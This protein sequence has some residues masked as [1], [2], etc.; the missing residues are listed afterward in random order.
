MSDHKHDHRKTYLNVWF[1]LMALTVITVVA[2]SINFGKINLFIAMAIASVKASLVILYF[3]HLKGDA[4]LNQVVFLSAFGFL[5]VFVLL[6]L[7]DV[8]ARPPVA[9][10]VVTKIQGITVNQGV[11][12]ARLRNSTPEQIQKGKAIYMAQC[13]TCHGENADGLGPAAVAF[14]PKPRDFKSGYWKLGGEPSR[15]YHTVENGMP[16][17]PM[18]AFKGLTPEDRWAVV[19]FIRSFSPNTPADT[20]ATLALIG[21]KPDGTPQSVSTEK[22]IPELPVDFIIEQIV[23]ENP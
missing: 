7:S 3:M 20:R 16:G 1:I 22:V 6:T 9:P 14:N 4:T 8:I 23:K 11:V 15:V 21:L 5:A 19:H 13:A 17:T 2:A 10:V 18:P 12:M